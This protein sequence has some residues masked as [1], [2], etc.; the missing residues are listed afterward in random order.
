MRGHFDFGVHFKPLL[1][2]LPNI[3]HHAIIDKKR[4]QHHYL[5]NYD[6]IFTKTEN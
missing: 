4:M 3:Q 6:F 2:L 1:T 5:H